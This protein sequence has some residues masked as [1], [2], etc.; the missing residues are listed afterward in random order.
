MYI[1]EEKY[2]MY[3][4]KIMMLMSM[5]LSCSMHMGMLNP[6][7]AA[8]V[9]GRETPPQITMGNGELMGRDEESESAR[10]YPPAA[11]PRGSCCCW[12]F[13]SPA[14]KN[15]PRTAAIKAAQPNNT[16]TTGS[17]KKSPQIINA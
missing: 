12:C 3:T 15:D 4:R 10:E 8:Q 2:K 17:Q 1:Y 16:Q 6:E 5:A 11:K 13:G 9:I 7:V 14:P